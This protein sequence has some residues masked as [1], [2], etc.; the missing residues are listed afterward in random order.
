MLPEAVLICNFPEP[1][2]Q[3]PVLLSL[4]EVRTFFHEFGHLLHRIFSGKVQYAGM[5]RPEWDF[6][7]APSELFEEW[8]LNP[9]VVSMFARHYKTQEALP[10]KLAESLPSLDAVGRSLNVIWLLHRSALSLAHHDG[11]AGREDLGKIAMEQARRY[12][13]YPILE[14][15]HEQCSFGHLGNPGY[16]SAYYTYLW[17]RVIA[18]D[19]F[20]AFDPGNLMNRAPMQRFRRLVLEPGG[21]MP[22]ADLVKRFLGRPF[23]TEAFARWLKED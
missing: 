5:S 4:N 7:E 23:N 20:T 17:S 3:D 8:A 13:P 2:E 11:S 10:K 1:S 9:R 21:S 14:G 16:A 15:S 18:C 6:V 19:L 22:A 12:L